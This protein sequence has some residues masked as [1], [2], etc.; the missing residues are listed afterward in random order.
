MSETRYCTYCGWEYRMMAEHLQQVHGISPDPL[1]VCPDCQGSGNDHYSK[2][3]PAC[4]GRRVVA[5]PDLAD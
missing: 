3:C 5:N 2:P 4:E 1:V